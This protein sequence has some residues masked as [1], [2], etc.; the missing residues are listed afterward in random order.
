M[1]NSVSVTQHHTLT[2]SVIHAMH[3]QLLIHHVQHVHINQ[4]IILE[5]AQLVVDLRPQTVVEQHV[6]AVE[7]ELYAEIQ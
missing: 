4:L 6:S 1:A 2:L 3:A 7:E 5:I